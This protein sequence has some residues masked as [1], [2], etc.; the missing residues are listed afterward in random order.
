MQSPIKIYTGVVKGKP[1]DQESINNAY[2]YFEGMGIDITIEKHKTRRSNPQNKYLWIGV[3]TPIQE[4]IHKTTGKLFSCQ[5]IHDSYKSKGYFG[6]KESIDG[7]IPKGSSE[8]TTIEFMEAIDRIQKEWA[9]KGLIIL[10]PQQTDF[11]EE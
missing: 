1:V 6:F 11:I 8:A 10:D 7:D 9:E 4:F 5:D 2:L 3:W